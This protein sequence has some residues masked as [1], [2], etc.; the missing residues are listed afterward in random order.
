MRKTD[1]QSIE[2]SLD[3]LVEQVVMSLDEI[4]RGE[5]EQNGT[6]YFEA[7]I[8]GLDR[9]KTRSIRK[10]LHLRSAQNGYFARVIESRTVMCNGESTTAHKVLIGV[11]LGKFC[12]CLDGTVTIEFKPD[13]YYFYLSDGVKYFL[14]WDEYYTLAE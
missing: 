12:S 13:Y 8:S 10:Y 9:G 14:S 3:T 5:R 6:L 11:D 7:R 4:A 2:R 1:K